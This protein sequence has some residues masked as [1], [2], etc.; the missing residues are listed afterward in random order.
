MMYF[1]LA[2]R[3]AT[4]EQKRQLIEGLE[5]SLADVSS[6]L[7][8]PR[9]ITFVFFGM[10]DIKSVSSQEE[11]CDS[12]LSGATAKSPITGLSLPAVQPLPKPATAIEMNTQLILQAI[13]AQKINKHYYC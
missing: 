5:S 8:L 10:Q 7:Y 3:A 1:I 9:G 13:V 12:V 11:S 2:C 6:T 4:T